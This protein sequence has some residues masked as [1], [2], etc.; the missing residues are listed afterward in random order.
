MVCAIIHDFYNA[1]LISFRSLDVVPNQKIYRDVLAAV[2]II[3]D[4]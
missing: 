1:K 2:D 4:E 3:Y